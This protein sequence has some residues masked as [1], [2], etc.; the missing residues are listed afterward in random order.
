MKVN[1]IGGFFPKDKMSEY[2]QNSSGMIHYAAN[3]LQQSI[4]AG[5]KLFP[6]I[7]TKLITAPFLV[8]YPQYKKVFIK[9]KKV[10]IIK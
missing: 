2:I 1:F 10:R 3:S 8:N 5:L 7:E 4:I 9:G 6:D